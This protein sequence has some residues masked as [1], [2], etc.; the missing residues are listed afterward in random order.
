MARKT[1]NRI[2]A[3]LLSG[4]G[5]LTFIASTALNAQN[6]SKYR[7]DVIT[8]TAIGALDAGHYA[9]KA[10]ITTV[11]P[12][13][14]IPF[15]IHQFPG[16]R[17]MLEGA[18]TIHWKEGQSQTFAAGSTYYE[19]PGENHPAGVMAATNPTD[20]IARVLIVELIR[21]DAP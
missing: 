14:E 11:E 6:E 13:G 4:A 21:V 19:G 16:I 15:H 8:Q 18:L 10:T 17:Y 9:F 12:R 2:L 7:S 5:A 20:G 1:R 3:V